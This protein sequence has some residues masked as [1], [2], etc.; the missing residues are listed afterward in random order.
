MKCGTFSRF[1]V[2]LALLVACS[3]CSAQAVDI[4]S[5]PP[6]D[7]SRTY[8]VPGLVLEQFRTGLIQLDEQLTQ[9]QAQLQT[10]SGQ[11]TLAEQRLADSQDSFSAYRKRTLWTEIGLGTL[12]VIL[13][14]ALFLK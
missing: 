8:Q 14:T 3:F 7:T 13:T 11:L 6:F 4:H 2:V 5:L 1:L 9:A 12:A 10:A